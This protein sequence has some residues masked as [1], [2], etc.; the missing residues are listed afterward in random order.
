MVLMRNAGGPCCREGPGRREAHAFSKAVLVIQAGLIGLATAG[1]ALAQSRSERTSAALASSPSPTTAPRVLTGDDARRVAALEK[2]I[3]ELRKNGRLA[4]AVAPAREVLAIR[5]KALGE[6][7]LEI[8]NSY[9]SLATI[10]EGLRRS[11]EADQLHC[12]VLKIRLKRVRNDDVA[13]IS[14]YLDA[15]ELQRH[16]G[17]F[18]A[19]ESLTLIALQKYRKL[20][21]FDDFETAQV[22]ARLAWRLEKEGHGS[23]AEL[24]FRQ[25]L[26]I[27]HRVLPVD[28]TRTADAS[29]DLARVLHLKGKDDEAERLCRTALEI[30][31]RHRSEADP[32]IVA[33]RSLLDL[34][35]KVRGKEAVAEGEREA[36]PPLMAASV[37]SPKMTEPLRAVA[38]AGESRGA[39]EG[40]G[41]VD[42]LAG[43]R[44]A[45]PF[46]GSEFQIRAT[47]TPGAAA[48]RVRGLERIQAELAADAALV[49]WVDPASPPRVPGPTCDYWGCVVR[50]RGEPAWIRIRGGGPHGEWTADDD[51]RP[52]QTCEVLSQ[53]PE[54]HPGRWRDVAGALARQWLTPLEPHLASQGD[55]PAVTRLIVLPPR[56]LAGVPIEAMVDS[57]PDG[58]PKYTVSYTLSATSFVRVRAKR[59]QGASANRLT[60][61]DSPRLLALGDPVFTAPDDVEPPTP[62]SSPDQQRA[63]QVPTPLAPTRREVPR[64]LPGTRREVLAIAA[65]F[66]RPETL[67]GSEASEQQLDVLAKAGRLR[68]FGFLHLATHGKLDSDNAQRSALL[69][70]RDRLSDPLQQILVGREVY[71]GELSAEQVL[72]TWVLD[73]ELVTISACWSGAARLN[74]FGADL[75]FSHALILKG[76]KSVV[77]SL[78]NVDDAATA[79]LMTRFYQNL[80]GRRQGL[81]RPLPKAE[82]LV[83][84]KTWLRTRTAAEVKRLCD[85]LPTADRMEKV[86]GPPRSTAKTARPYEHPYYWAAFILIGDPD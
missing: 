58:R 54:D 34:C 30:D 66:D 19:A 59:R 25:A 40:P 72:L 70:A 27:Y 82:A 84:A 38:N 39:A 31:R 36:H 13:T 57:R 64:P 55:L 62:G 20:K 26:A 79:I 22:L 75:G 53:R 63:V 49:A 28:D 29:F 32:Q 50:Q 44:L 15:V 61:A 5:L 41:Q 60:G 12:Q 77:L 8:E 47:P 16:K 37:Q 76:A 6:D 11:V 80:L 3:G 69:L 24:P 56:A 86:S 78:W 14:C 23:D 4:E 46:R 73:A 67:L 2:T 1:G 18:A 48:G 74:L 71:D 65:L 85:S 21:H 17:N 10:L 7:H 68:E 33:Y 83:E 81:D 45:A 43:R 42:G 52:V 51:R 9:Q 35:L